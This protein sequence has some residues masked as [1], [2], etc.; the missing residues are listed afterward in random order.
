MS[1]NQ[2]EQQAAIGTDVVTVKHGDNVEFRSYLVDRPGH[3]ASLKAAEAVL[4]VSISLAHP[5][6][7]VWP[8]FRNFDR[9]MNR[10]GF[11]WD[12]LPAERENRFAYLANKGTANDMDYGSDGS[13]TQYV[14]RKVIPE[15]LIYFDSLPLPLVGK[16]GVWTGHNLM[17]LV[18][19]GGAT[20]IAIFMEHTW[21]S[22]T[23]TIEQ[24]RAEARSIMFDV[25]VAF[26]RD[27][28]VPDLI[29]AVEAG[30]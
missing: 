20:K 17:S 16:D 30:K 4:E 10:F 25:A 3:T 5:V 13:R 22:Q 1:T 18:E 7:R 15:T 14:V 29:A 2:Q 21:Y 6:K 9:W 24:L 11:V 27:Y 12:G 19:E 26:W 8:I 28:F 23:L